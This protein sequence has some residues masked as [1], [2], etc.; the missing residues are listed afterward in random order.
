M[1]A[2]AFLAGLV[3]VAASPAAAFDPL[4]DVAVSGY[5]DVRAVAPAGP[6]SWLKGGLGKFRYGSGDSPIT[7]GE[8]VMQAS[9][10]LDDGLSAVTVLRLE[11]RTPSLVDALETYLRYAP[12]GGGDIGWSVKA[13]AFFPTLSL[14]NDDLGWASPYTLT[15]SAINSW[16]GDELRTIGSEATL[17]WKSGV[18]TFSALGA[19]FCCNDEAGIL[20][21]DRGWS[22]ED[23]PTGLT[24]RVRLPDT[25]LQLFHKLPDQ[26]TGMFDEID[27][28]VGWYGGL[29]W[30]M[31][32][33]G[34]LMAMRY[35]NRADPDAVSSRDTS[36]ETK[37]WSFGARTQVGHLVLIAQ[38]L[39]G[40]TAVAVASGEAETKFQSGFLLASY[41]LNDWRLSVREDLFQTRH[42][43]AT[44][45]PLSED[46]D[47]FTASLSW[48][49]L[50]RVRLTGEVIALHNRRLEY[51]RAG[52]GGP[53]RT[54]TQLQ[55]DARFFL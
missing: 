33:I 35:D 7:F 12:A 23:R 16:V 27:G 36:W 52:L 43:S 39:S 25:T 48:S 29:A 53:D 55:L 24:E 37:F 31:P 50:D 13:G 9:A 44:P 41:D 28:G 20:I 4:G 30:Q 3:F 2:A 22:L 45:H 5:V 46:G 18:G 40:Y 47:A 6:T 19:L 26:R 34:K 10:R 14:E 15:P 32:G 21:A 49:G 8:G 1:R 42:L 51:V 17:R 38:Q 11:P 54:D